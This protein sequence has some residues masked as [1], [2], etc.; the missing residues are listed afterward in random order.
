GRAGQPLPALLHFGEPVEATY[1]AAVDIGAFWKKVAVG[2]H[3]PPLAA[4]S[5]LEQAALAL[6]P[7]HEILGRVP[8]W[9]GLRLRSLQGS[10]VERHRGGEIG[11][12][13]EDPFPA[14]RL[15]ELEPRFLSY[16]AW[17]VPLR[18]STPGPILPP[19]QAGAAGLLAPFDPLHAVLEHHFSP[20][21]LTRRSA[22][23]FEG[24]A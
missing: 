24:S 23:L 21:S 18:G 12:T 14:R 17:P 5:P 3:P 6:C 19:L 8:G 11:L 20:F 1:H 4:A 2:V 13:A 15:E 7:W 16:V 9:L 10:A 22:A